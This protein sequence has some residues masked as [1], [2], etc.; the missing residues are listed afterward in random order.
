MKFLLVVAFLSM[1]ACRAP[2][3]DPEE[4][5]EIP[6]TDEYEVK[7]S[8][9]RDLD[10]ARD[11]IEV[12]MANEPHVYVAVGC[13]RSGRYTISCSSSPSSS[14]ETCRAWPVEEESGYE[15]EETESE[16]ED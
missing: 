16:D 10:C 7:S 1:A 2:V 14:A 3:R 11:D 13:G 4:P 15:D 12:G 9:E 8:A 5:A 6:S